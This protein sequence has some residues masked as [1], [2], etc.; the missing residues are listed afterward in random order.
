MTGLRVANM[1][2]T[3]IPILTA[4]SSYASAT[5]D[6][7]HGLSE[8][9][10]MSL[11]AFRAEHLA[12]VMR[13]L[14]GTALD[15]EDEW[16]NDECLLLFLKAAKFDLD[17]AVSRLAATM[18]WR[19]DFRPTEIDPAVVGPHCKFGDQFLTGF[20]KHGRPIM[21]TRPK[22][23]YLH[24][25]D[26]EGSIRYSL[27]L[28]EKAI[29]IMPKG[30][31]KLTV[32]TDFEGST[33]FNGFASAIYLKF[34]NIL[35]THYPER[36]GVAICIRPTWYLSFL[37]GV[38]APFMDPITKKKLVFIK[39]ASQSASKPPAMDNDEVGG[40]RD[41]IFEFVDVDQL[42]GEYGGDHQFNFDYDIYWEA[43]TKL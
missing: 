33:M 11:K 24:N 12:T 19:R 23:G 29:K 13:G 27:L 26:P 31:T 9:E 28:I 5:Y 20:D 21:Y 14:T 30:V 1:T 16:T 34:L 2:P 32:I 7:F 36:L 42:R 17:V 15:N 22:H 6:P 40:W 4:P 43:F 25:K 41:S 18:Q 35:A 37:Y 38:I 39:D 3:P 8:S 10:A